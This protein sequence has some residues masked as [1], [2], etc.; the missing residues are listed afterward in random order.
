[1]R[2]F[3]LTSLIL[4]LSISCKKEPE[5]ELPCPEPTSGTLV[6][7]DSTFTLQPTVIIE[8]MGTRTTGFFHAENDGFLTILHL[9]DDRL[10]LNPD[11]TLDVKFYMQ[12]IPYIMIPCYS[13][14]PTSLPTGTYTFS[15]VEPHPTFS[16][17]RSVITYNYIYEQGGGTLNFDYP[18]VQSGTLI[19]NYLCE[20]TYNISLNAK[21]TNGKSFQA[22][23][24][25]KIIRIDSR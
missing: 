10:I 1:M 23:L 4:L 18:D 21:L 19:I 8:N 20:E 6:V 25:T 12:S 5:I 15:N 24:S 3:I 13:S 14:D 17:S 9:L 11:T 2:N 7:D 22:S 16:F